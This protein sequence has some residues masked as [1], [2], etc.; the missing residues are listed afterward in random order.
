MD[1]SIANARYMALTTFRRD[2]T[3]VSTPVWFVD[4]GGRILV[5]TDASS[6]KV[7]RIRSNSRVTV[8][9]CDARGRR[10]APAVHG[11]A[12]VLD[13]SVGSEVH[14]LLERKHPL[15]KPLVDAWGS[16]NRAVRRKARPGAAY[17]EIRLDPPHA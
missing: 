11:T 6:G 7:K 2:G 12:A 15:M 13:Q 9:A 8:A 16:L 4:D 3:P 10:R 1:A 17:L 14:Q 5:W